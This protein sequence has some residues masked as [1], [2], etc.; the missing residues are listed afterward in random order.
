[1]FVSLRALPERRAIEHGRL[2]GVVNCELPAAASA[3]TTAARSAAWA[4]ASALWPE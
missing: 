3:A 4:A 1:M 2:P